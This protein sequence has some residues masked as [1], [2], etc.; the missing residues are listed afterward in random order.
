MEKVKVE[1]SPFE[2]NK[3]LYGTGASPANVP[4]PSYRNNK[5]SP[6]LIGAN[7]QHTTPML[8]IDRLKNLVMT[9]PPF[10]L[11]MTFDPLP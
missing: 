11:P 7:I 4:A 3:S 2:E 1:A 8:T 9:P 5:T 10:T 6:M